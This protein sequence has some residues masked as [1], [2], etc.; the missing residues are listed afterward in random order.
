MRRMILLV[1]MTLATPLLLAQPAPDVHVVPLGQGRTV[2]L[3]SI[4]PNTPVAAS[5]DDP[6]EIVTWDSGVAYSYDPSG[7]IRRIGNDSFA[8]D[9]VQRLIQATVNGV[10]RNYEYDLY[11]NRQKCRQDVG[12]AMEGDCQGY[13]IDPGNN[14]IIGATYD[15][16]GTGNV[17]VL[18]THTY[19]YDA[20]NMMVSRQGGEP[21]EF[22]YTANDERIAT[23]STGSRTWRWTVRDDRHKVLREF[24]SSG[25]TN[26][27]ASFRWVKDF[28]WR[29]T[30]LLA[31]LQQEGAVTTRYHYHLDHQGTPRRITDYDDNRVG[32]RD[33][34]AFGPEKDSKPE[35]SFTR[36]RYTGHERDLAG[37]P[38]GTLDYMHA[39]YYNPELGR[40]LSIDPVLGDPKSPQSWNRYTYVSNNP[41]NATDPTGKCEQKEGDPPCLR[42]RGEIT[43]TAQNPSDQEHFLFLQDETKELDLPFMGDWSTAHL[44]PNALWTSFLTKQAEK[45]AGHPVVPGTG[46]LYILMGLVGGRVSFLE[47]VPAVATQ[48]MVTIYRAVGSTEL[49]TIMS[50]GNYGSAPSMGGKYFALTEVGAREFAAH[51][52][53]AGRQMTVTSTSVPRSV[54]NQGHQFNDP[55][56]AGPSIHFQEQQLPTFYKAMSEVKIHR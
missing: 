50:A 5:A 10:E 47:S 51:P 2:D 45:E 13:S 41:I 54:Y 44:F 30:M 22:I 29:D 26:G 27:T 40:F 33:Y 25:G 9:H 34:F 11:G 6:K 12:T 38:L 46:T 53:N 42:W 43:V 32:F 17:I 15:P 39:R 7:N 52:F 35:P 55:G 31:T 24:T 4:T 37:N 18:G 20:F 36:I 1:A 23:Y 49:K 16:N 3:R 28:I 19:K 8:Y 21:Q 48:E 56:G 14:H